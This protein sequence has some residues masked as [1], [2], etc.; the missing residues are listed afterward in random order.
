M[1][2][3]D[4]ENKKIARK[5]FNRIALSREDM[6]RYY[7]ISGKT[8][9]LIKNPNVSSIKVSNVEFD[10]IMNI[11]NNRENQLFMVVTDRTISRVKQLIDLLDINQL[12]NILGL[13]KSYIEQLV[14]HQLSIMRTTWKEKID[15]LYQEMTR[16]ITV[17]LDDLC[18]EVDLQ[19]INMQG[20]RKALE[21][22]KKAFKALEIGKTYRIYQKRYLS[23][24][25]DK[26]L[27]FEG[28][29]IE[30]YSKYYLGKYHNR[31]VTFLKNLLYLP[32]TIVEEVTDNEFATI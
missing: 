16:D 23:Q 12:A 31:N 8:T 18:P 13:E 25:I 11:V 15:D 32:D 7:N 26:E 4:G 30:E 27:V 29:I 24:R 19:K 3:L 28:T 2:T 20:Y 21:S 9:Q 10:V 17:P 1:V 14:N 5:Y 6:K 22:N